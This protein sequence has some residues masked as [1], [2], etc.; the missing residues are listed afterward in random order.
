[1]TGEV[2]SLYFSDLPA[3]IHRFDSNA[4]ILSAQ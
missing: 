4:D 3:E 1:M 2:D